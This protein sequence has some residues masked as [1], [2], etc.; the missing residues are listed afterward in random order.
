[1]ILNQKMILDQKMIVH[2]LLRY[3]EFNKR[4]RKHPYDYITYMSDDIYDVRKVEDLPSYKEAM[5]SENSTKS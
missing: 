3:E 5:K 2:H 1:M 4:E